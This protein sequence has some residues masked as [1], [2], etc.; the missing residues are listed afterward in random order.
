[1][2]NLLPLCHETYEPTETHQLQT[3]TFNTCNRPKSGSNQR[4]D[5]VQHCVVRRATITVLDNVL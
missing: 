5:D 1:M 2:L 3:N 4:P